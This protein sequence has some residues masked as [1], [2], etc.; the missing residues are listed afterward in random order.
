MPAFPNCAE[1]A[2]VKHPACA[3][4]INSSGL[5]PFAFS[6]RVENEYGVLESTPLS[7]DIVPFPSL[8][9]PFHTAEALR[10]IDHSSFVGPFWRCIHIQT[11]FPRVLTALYLPCHFSSS[12]DSPKVPVPLF[13]PR[14][15]F[16]DRE[17]QSSYSTQ[18]A[19]KVGLVSIP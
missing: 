5:V 17:G 18:S 9:D 10:T 19:S 11:L 4:A 1:R 3:A 13:R 7:L 16:S 15:C 6:K 12:N 8:S 14:L 2:M